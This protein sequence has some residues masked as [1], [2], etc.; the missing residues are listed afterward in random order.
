MRQQKCFKSFCLKNEFSHV[1]HAVVSIVYITVT[2]SCWLACW[3]VGIRN[4]CFRRSEGLCVTG[5]RVINRQNIFSVILV[6][7]LVGACSIYMLFIPDS[8]ISKFRFC[9]FITT[10]F[11]MNKNVWWQFA[12]NIM[13]KIVLIYKILYRKCHLLRNYNE[14]ITSRVSY[15]ICYLKV[16]T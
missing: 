11:A 13:Y 5:K 8:R 15:E 4:N 7:V 10:F 2:R 9:Y 6:L 16:F 1:K 3:T 12:S 14:I